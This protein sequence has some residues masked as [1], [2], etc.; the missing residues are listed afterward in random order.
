M[1][2]QTKA[3]R[4]KYHAELVRRSKLPGHPKVGR[5]GS[6]KRWARSLR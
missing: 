1:S 5:P 2:K 4:K 3:F 6:T